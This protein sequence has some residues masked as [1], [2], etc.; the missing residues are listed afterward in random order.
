MAPVPIWEESRAWL[1]FPI[2]KIFSEGFM[3][4]ANQLLNPEKVRPVEELEVKEGH[5]HIPHFYNDVMT[6]GTNRGC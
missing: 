2:R 6:L 3:K 1:I 4:K 5:L